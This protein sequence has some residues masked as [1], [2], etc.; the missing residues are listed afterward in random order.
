MQSHIKKTYCLVFSFC[1]FFISGA[2]A[3]EQRIA[4]SLAQIYKQDTVTDTAKLELLFNL[5]FNE[6][7]DNTQGLRYADELISLSQQSGNN[8]YLR[9]G[10]FQKGI[11]ERLLG[12][13][14]EALDAFFKSAELAKTLHNLT[15]EGDSYGAIGDIYSS[16]NNHAN[17][18]TLL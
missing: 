2:V 12:N 5:A 13:L 14:D 16:A 1:L 6:M 17:A 9:A 15:G 11:K 7:R 4:D 18:R 10:Y 3:Q 8:K